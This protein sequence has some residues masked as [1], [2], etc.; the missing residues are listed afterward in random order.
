MDKNRQ[1]LLQELIEKMITVIKGIHS[2]HGFPFGELKLSRPQVMILFFI[3]KKK[4]GVSAKEIATFLN[5]TSGA[6]TQFIDPLVKDK[7]V[8]REEDPQDRR[9]IRITLAKNTKEKLK[10]FKKKYYKSVSPAFD[11]LK[12]SEIKQFLRFLN[13]IK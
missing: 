6:I 2:G 8:K 3:S 5:V 9:I 11:G 13:K 12:E 10:A 7:L 4:G 1:E